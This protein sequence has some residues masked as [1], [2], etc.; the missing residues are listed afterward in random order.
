MK[1]HKYLCLFLTLVLLF[2][3]L[4][5]ASAAETGSA[6][7]PPTEETSDDIPKEEILEEDIVIDGFSVAQYA[8]PTD[9]F[10]DEPHAAMVIE[11]SSDT[12]LFA[13]DAHEQNYPASLTKIMTCYLALT[14]GNLDDVLT[15]S[16]E[17]LQNLHESGS[18]ADLLEGEQM[19]LENMLYCTMVASANE[20]CNVIAEHIS[21]SVEAFV[22]LMNRTARELGCIGTNFVNPHG[23]HDPD[24]YTCKDIW[25][26]TMAQ[27]FSTVSPD[28]HDE[29]DIQYSIP[30]A[31]RCAYT[32]YGC[33]EPLHDR[34]DKL[35]QYP[36]LRKVGVS[37]W[38]DIEMS[39]EAI[40]G[41]YVFS[42]KPNPANV[43]SV[44][45]P[46]VIR[47]EITETVEA[48]LKYRCPLDITLK[49]I[50]TVG[51]CPENLMVWAQT[52]SDVL[53]KYYDAP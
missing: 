11:L 35:K 18:T 36:N 46:E 33:C 9:I 20:A 51:Y 34:I 44:T 52:V 16:P 31:S 42:R 48:C 53:D 49:D 1:D 15:V 40:G 30:L 14:Y 39:A 29:F 17:A 23:L 8:D 43:S 12:V 2:S 47:R 27:M 10:K 3:F 37:P 5:P 24:H 7:L 21:G 6:D 19:T 4:L 38:S 26:R 50:S 25:F 32:Y 41:N 28:M 45:D 13:L 22:D